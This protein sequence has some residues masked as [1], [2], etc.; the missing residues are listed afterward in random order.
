M[1]AASAPAPAAR[2]VDR[3]ALGRAA[4]E[5]AAQFLAAQQLT[6]LKRNYR[7][8]AGELDIVAL[9]RDAV[10]V[11]AEV[12]LRSRSNYG[13]GAAS[14]DGIKQRRIVRA[15]RHLLTTHRQLARCAVRFD[16]LDVKPD[17]E[18]FRVEWIRHA[19]TA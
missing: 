8:R 1:C 15:S 7:C 18:A 13:G 2:C 10:L 5:A 16:V 6:I 11:I 12:R 4:E 14:V 3:Q 17:G 9:E 19:F